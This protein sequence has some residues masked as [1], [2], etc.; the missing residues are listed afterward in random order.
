MCMGHTL[1]IIDIYCTFNN[2]LCVGDG[3]SGAEI[4][5]SEG[6]C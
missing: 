2:V 4:D 6:I 3:T 1:Q 5:S